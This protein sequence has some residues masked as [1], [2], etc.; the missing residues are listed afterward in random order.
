M[1]LGD[2]YAD[3]GGY[4]TTKFSITGGVTYEGPE[5]GSS[6]L[7][8]NFLLGYFVAQDVAL[9]ILVET[10]EIDDETVNV[11]WFGGSVRF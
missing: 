2:N 7:G 9:E 1:K 3:T 5:A 6:A 10:E 11:I 8:L 4:P